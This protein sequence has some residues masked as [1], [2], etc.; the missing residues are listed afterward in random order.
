MG[1]GEA[2]LCFVEESFDDGVSVIKNNLMY[3]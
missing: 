2:M 3:P 1:R